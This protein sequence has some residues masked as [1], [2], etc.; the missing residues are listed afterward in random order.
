MINP[1]MIQKLDRALEMFGGDDCVSCVE[2][3]HKT[4]NTRSAEDESEKKKDINPKIIQKHGALGMFSLGD[5][6]FER[7]CVE[8]DHEIHNTV[9]VKDENEKKKVM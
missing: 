9:P 6:T 5:Q 3:D 7:F 8:E 4:N 1:E 2:G